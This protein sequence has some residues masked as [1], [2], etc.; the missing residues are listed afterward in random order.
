M[1]S[2]IVARTTERLK[3]KP[4]VLVV[5]ARTNLPRLAQERQ[6]FETI[7]EKTGTRL[8]FVNLL[9][10]Q[11]QHDWTRPRQMLTG[12]SRLEKVIPVAFHCYQI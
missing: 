4:I 5:Q 9:D 8:K 7:A 11:D 12:I 3:R 2:E 6:L 10:T 1:T